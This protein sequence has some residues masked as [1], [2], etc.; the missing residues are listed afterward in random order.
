MYKHFIESWKGFSFIHELWNRDK[1]W[2]C[3]VCG[4]VE[5]VVT[6]MPSSSLFFIVHQTFE[7]V[8]KTLPLGILWYVTDIIKVASQH[9]FQSRKIATLI[10]P[11]LMHVDI[12]YR[13]TVMMCS[14]RTPFQFP[15]A[16]QIGFRCSKKWGPAMFIN[17][18]PKT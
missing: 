17:E 2:H 3:E 10:S 7:S 5:V 12:N 16:I 11:N 14:S 4:T 1:E 9:C 6:R 13:G 8:Q 18:I 15:S